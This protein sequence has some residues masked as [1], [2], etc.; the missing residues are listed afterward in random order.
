MIATTTN[1]GKTPSDVTQPKRSKR[2]LTAAESRSNLLERESHF[3]RCVALVAP[4]GRYVVLTFERN[5]DYT[6]AEVVAFQSE[7]VTTFVPPAGAKKPDVEPATIDAYRRDGWVCSGHQTI[8]RPVVL[9]HGKLE[10]VN[11][12]HFADC[13]NNLVRCH[14]DEADGA[15][16]FASL[17]AQHADAYGSREGNLS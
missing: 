1:N 17:A 12:G 2:R 6:W 4:Q 13:A 8:T 16:I 11:L 14:W 3:P 9:D 10:T 5:G 15:K 7:Q